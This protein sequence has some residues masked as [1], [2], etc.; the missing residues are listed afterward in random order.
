MED[1]QDR[2]LSDFERRIAASAPHVE[3]TVRDEWLF[4]AGVAQGRRAGRRAAWSSAV[5]ASAAS[6]ALC[7]AGAYVSQAT[8]SDRDSSQAAAFPAPAA[9]DGSRP[10]DAAI[11]ERDAGP[12]D[13]MLTPVGMR[14]FAAGATAPREV[15]P[16]LQRSEAVAT[17]SGVW[18]A[19]M[20]MTKWD[21]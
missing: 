5:L 16:I 17:D 7:L 14:G 13:G 21:F 3:P 12:G 9:A 1:A 8:R 19:G 6:I 10:L 20:N 15:A 11:V 4:Q 2:S 18:R